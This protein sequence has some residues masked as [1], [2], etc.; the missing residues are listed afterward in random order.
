MLPVSVNVKPHSGS[1]PVQ[2]R[3][4]LRALFNAN[5]GLTASIS[6]LKSS[7]A[8]GKPSFEAVS[9][10]LGHLCLAQVAILQLAAEVQSPPASDSSPVP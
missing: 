4:L 5:T 3:R 10:I 2:T 1:L 9:A 8:F 7:S 6:E